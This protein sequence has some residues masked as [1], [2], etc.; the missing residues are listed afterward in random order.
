MQVFCYFFVIEH[1][2]IW[3]HKKRVL[4][5]QTGNERAVLHCDVMRKGL[6]IYIY[7]WY[8]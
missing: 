3:G 7:I 1:H 6:K 8:I 4:L 5:A 2:P